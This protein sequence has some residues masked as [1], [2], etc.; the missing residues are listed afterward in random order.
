MT[1]SSA[2]VSDGLVMVCDVDLEVPDATRVHTVEVARN[3]AAEGLA[4]DLV[5]RGPDPEL[6]GVRYLQGQGADS[7]RVTRVA[8]LNAG[9]LALLWRRRAVAKRLYVRYRWSLMPVLIA[10][11][12]LGYRVVTQVDDIPYGRGY[13]FEISSVADHVQRIGT[14]LMGRLAAGVVAVT[15]ELKRLLVEQFHAPARRIAVLPNGV[16][17]D[18]FAPQPRAEALGRLG[19]DPS[20]R[21]VVFCGH[22]APW[23]DFDT[24]VRGF[25]VV[26]RNRPD[27]RLLLVG[28]GGERGQVE[29]LIDELGIRDRVIFTGYV[30]DR[31][32]VRDYVA[33]STVALSANRYDYRARIGVSPV[34]LAEYMAAGRAVVATELP[35]LRQTLEANGAG[36]VVPIDPEA[37]GQ[38]ILTL[39]D[40]DRADE[41]GARGRRLAEDSFSWRSIVRRTV[42]LFG[43]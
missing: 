18:F 22:F 28:E 37:M 32:R 31:E 42:P 24:I 6:E 21:Y 39:L 33:A 29:R 20:L 13:Q 12:L 10:G 17:I 1:V 5:A 11:R 38:A 27:V 26:A 4:V 40:G 43:L 35:G 16:D 3:F 8:T 14:T 23:V 19:L 15:P 7:Q 25:G 34:K 2:R 41:L 9:V 36:V 30:S